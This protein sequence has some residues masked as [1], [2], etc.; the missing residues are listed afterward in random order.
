M[1]E[2][3]YELRSDYIEIAEKISKDT[4]KTLM[5]IGGIDTGKTHTT[6]SFLKYFVHHGKKVGYID[7]DIGQ[8]NISVPATIGYAKLDG[9]MEDIEKVSPD[10][11]YFVGS[12]T[13]TR[14]LLPII[15]GIKKMIDKA[16]E[17]DVDIIMIDTTGMVKGIGGRVLKE[18][19]VELIAPATV[20][21]FAKGNELDHI[22][23][24][25]E[26][27]NITLYRFTPSEKIRI[28][29]LKHRRQNRERKFRKYFENSKEIVFDLSKYAL[30]GTFYGSGKKMSEE[31][32]EKISKSLGKKIVYGEK[33]PEGDYLISEDK[34][35]DVENSVSRILISASWF[36]GLL[37]GLLNKDDF[38]ES[39]GIIREFNFSEGKLTLLT[40]IQEESL[41][42]VVTLKFG[43]LN[44]TPQGKEVAKTLRLI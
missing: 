41:D 4:H 40:P 36:R 38:V 7:A 26:K 35:T 14:H 12:I 1:I 37:V 31:E 29:D 24:A 44:L 19:I 25:I 13:P 32:L 16:K 27:K 10:K 22:L 11:I 33:I 17:D 3:N 8:S 6:I 20:I 9:K 43:A 42:K 15:V 39:L 18:Y 2:K 5:F 23:K 30:M 21:A 28:K 34:I